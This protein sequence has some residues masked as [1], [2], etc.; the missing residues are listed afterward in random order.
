[1]AVLV[2]AGVVGLAGCGSTSVEGQ[3]ETTKPEAGEPTFDP[4]SIP[5]DVL[6]G[7][8][9]DPASEERDIGG[10]KQPGFSLC[11]WSGSNKLITVFATGRTLDEVRANE[12]FTDFTPVDLDGRSGFTFREV[13]DTMNQ[14]C[15]VVFSSGQDTVMIKSGYY[16]NQ[17]PAEGPCPL[18]IRNAQ[19]LAPSIPQ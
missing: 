11:T 4:C 8:G 5:E 18:A 16:T 15:D 10:V 3:A 14:Y 1:M 17:T 12:R 6:R 2:V 13:S 9:M 7:L 19:M